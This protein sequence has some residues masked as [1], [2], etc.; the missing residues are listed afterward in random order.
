VSDLVLAGGTVVTA[1]GSFRADVAVSGETIEAVGID[2]P[3]DG[4]E[5]VDVS[6]ARLMPG[7]IDGHTHMDMPFG[8][9]V[10]A[11]DWDTGT[12]AALAGGTTM[13]V[14]FSLQDVDGTLAE[15]VETWHGKAEGKAH[16]DYGLH[17]AITNLTDDVKR[18]IPSLPE[19][20]VATIKIFMAYKGTPLFTPDENL[21]EAMQIA[22]DAGV[23]VMVHAENGD[24][25]LKLQQQALAAGNTTPRYHALTRPEEV[26][27]EATGRAIRLAEIADTPLVVVHVTCD[28][29][30]EEIKR[31]HARGRPVYG[32]TCPQYL[33]FSYPEHLDQ[34]GFE[35]AKYVCSP[36]LRDPRNQPI[37][38]GGLQSGDLQIV[39]SDHCSFN[40]AGQKELGKDD[41]TAIPNGAPGAEERAAVL[42]THGVSEG[43]IS[44]NLMVAVLSTNQAR[45]HG[46]AGRKGALTPGADADIVVWDP[47][48]EIAATQSNRHGNVD[49]TPYEGMTFRGAPASVYVRGSLAYADGEV[50][51]PAGSGHFVPRSFRQPAPAAAVR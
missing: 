19:L 47:D 27:A 4:A 39:G 7:F 24:V 12:A 1:E 8:G 18:E 38:W 29:A 2:L 42:W 32:E 10:T 13:I 22:R 41:F 21:F 15:A 5:V 49:Y 28:G 44:E 6:G 17:V 51:A 43:R 50:L 23:L 48:L 25:I 26:E 16:I 14:D 40:Y 35:G 11:D 46:M 30:L 34:P 37:L 33:V 3:R 20:G 45:I 36:P 31:A 9:T